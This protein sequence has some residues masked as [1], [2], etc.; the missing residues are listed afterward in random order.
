M[1]ALHCACFHV[2]HL[3]PMLLSPCRAPVE[4]K[5]PLQAGGH[6][7]R[8]PITTSLRVGFLSAMSLMSQ[9]CTCWVFIT[10]CGLAAAAE[11][12]T[13]GATSFGQDTQSVYWWHQLTL[14]F[15]HWPEFHD[16]ELQ[17]LHLHE[18]LMVST[19]YVMA[20]C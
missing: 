2:L 14:S 3:T 19:E 9:I 6:H 20:I 18:V 12:P 13:G 8:L 17:P 11:K 15:R 5:F 10:V 4:D 16:L 7:R 1:C